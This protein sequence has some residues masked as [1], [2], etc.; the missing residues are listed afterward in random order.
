[1]L[2]VL[3]GVLGKLASAGGLAAKVGVGTAVA[4]TSV[5]AAAAAGVPPA[6]SVVEAV[7][8]LE[9][10]DE[11][12]LNEKIADT[13]AELQEDVTGAETSEAAKQKAAEHQAEAAELRNCR[14][15]PPEGWP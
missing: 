5:G 6:Q 11:K 9:L 4:A 3:S 15:F 10:A 13:A 14:D 12:D 1:M 7:T 8:P 2:E